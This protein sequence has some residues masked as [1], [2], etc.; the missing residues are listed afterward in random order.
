MP[1]VTMRADINSGRGR[2][3]H[4]HLSSC[5][6]CVM[7]HHAQQNNSDDALQWQSCSQA[8]LCIGATNVHPDCSSSPCVTSHTIS[9]F[10][11]APPGEQLL[12]VDCCF[13]H[14]GCLC[15]CGCLG[16]CIGCNGACAVVNDDRPLH[17]TTLHKRALHGHAICMLVHLPCL[18]LSKNQ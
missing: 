17:M 9:R 16:K 15:H 14:I 2:D 8:P 3:H 7:F 5:L 11:N 18:G 13:I 6:C 1:T 4:G 12:S 10:L